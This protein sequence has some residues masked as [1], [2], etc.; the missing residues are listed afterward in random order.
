MPTINATISGSGYPVVFIHGFCETSQMW[1]PYVEPLIEDYQVIC[2]DLPGFGK[3][4]LENTETTLEQVADALTNFLRAK[5]VH[6]AIFIGH[7]L[8]GY[9][10]LALAEKNPEMV[11][12]LGL[13]HSTAFADDDEAKHKREKAILFL[14][15]YPVPKFIEPF[16]PSLFFDA[17]REELKKEIE[18]STVIGLQTTA[19]T[20]IAYT[21]AMR[22]RP[23]RFNL[24]KSLPGHCLFIGGSHDSRVLMADSQRHIEE[25]DLV[26]GYILAATA[27]MGMFERPSETLQIIRDFLL[28]TI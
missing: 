10:S 17:R 1:F 11:K 8:G 27:H 19:E 14:Q 9:V 25:R 16:I 22:D 3:S 4:S 20:I 5:G 28:K 24:W 23:D 12:G 13:F 18:R 15:K 2:P 26:D 7:S 6:E 21:K